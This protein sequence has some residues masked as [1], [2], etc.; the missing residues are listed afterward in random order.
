MNIGICEV[1]HIVFYLSN[2]IVSSYKKKNIS[3]LSRA[4]LGPV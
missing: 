1:S 2:N 3:K 4:F